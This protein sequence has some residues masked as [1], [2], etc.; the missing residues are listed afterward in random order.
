MKKIAVL[1][2]FFLGCQLQAQ[3]TDTFEIKAIEG[4]IGIYTD[5]GSDG[6]RGLAINGELITGY[7]KNLFSLNC[8]TGFGLIKQYDGNHDLQAIMTIDMLYGRE[9]ELSKV[10]SFQPQVGVGYFANGNTS[11]SGSKE[12]IGFPVRAKLYFK[13]SDDF[14]IGINPNVNFN[15]VN[16]FYSANLLLTFTFD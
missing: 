10:I 8:M 3:E 6:M 11:D 15:N 14:K 1:F 4:G 5:L 13:T 12:A 2:T 9:F 7:K 16:T